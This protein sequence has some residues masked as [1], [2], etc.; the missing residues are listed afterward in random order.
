MPI[1]GCFWKW[2]GPDLRQGEVIKTVPE[3][4]IVET[5]IEE[6]MRLAEGMPG[7]DGASDDA[8]GPNRQLIPRLG[9]FASSAQTTFRSYSTSSIGDA[10]AY[11]VVAE[12]VVAAQLDPS[13]LVVRRGVGTSMAT[14]RSAIFAGPNVILVETTAAARAAF[15][16]RLAQVGRRSSAIVGY[17]DEVL[18]GGRDS[19]LPGVRAARSG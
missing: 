12:R 11:C 4:Q 6:A 15:A 8:A 5:L 18:D 16:D 1:W 14:L 7:S 3:A 9:S 2:Q 19:K 13:G 10:D 17:R